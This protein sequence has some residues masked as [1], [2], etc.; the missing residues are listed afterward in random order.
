MV[1][2]HG[3]RIGR[4]HPFLFGVAVSALKTSTSDLMAQKFVERREEVDWRRNFIF[5]TW[6]LMYLGGVQYFI[7]VHLFA[8][9]WFPMAEAFAAQPWRAKLADRAGQRN[10]LAQVF[11]DQ[12]VHHPFLLYPAFYQVKELIEGGTPLQGWQKYRR[13]QME[14]MKL[15]WSV[16]IPVFLLNFSFSPIWLRVPVVAVVSFGFTAAL[17]C[18]RGAPEE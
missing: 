1:L 18:L 16:W 2:R 15:T 11:F 12:F 7:Y 4:K 17:S 8:R 3:A 6:G 13:N 9:R 14:D 5:F 10:V